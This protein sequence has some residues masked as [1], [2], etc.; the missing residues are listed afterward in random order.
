M[1]AFSSRTFGFGKDIFRRYPI[2]MIVITVTLLIAAVLEI[3]SL[4]AILPVMNNLLGSEGETSDS[5]SQI[6]NIVPFEIQTVAQGLAFIVIFMAFRGVFLFISQYLNGYVAT[7]LERNMRDEMMMAVLKADWKYHL[8]QN[9]G[10]LTS[11]IIKETEYCAFAVTKFGGF[12]VGLIISTIL[13]ITSIFVSWEAFLVFSISVLPYLLLGRWINR[14]IREYSAKRVDATAD[15]SSS[16]IDSLS[17]SK[18]IKAMALENQA[19]SRFEGSSKIVVKNDMKIALYKAL[20]TAY[21]EVFGIMTLSVLIYMMFTFD[22][23]N[24]Q[25]LV[26]F[27]LLMY[28]AYSQV[29]RM[30][31]SLSALSDYLPSYDV[32]KKMLLEAQG[33]EEKIKDQ[34]Y[35]PQKEGEIAIQN[36]SISYNDNDRIIENL[37]LSIA[38]NKVTAFVGRS[39][40]GKTTL[41]DALM[42]LIEPVQ[43]TIE[44]GQD[45]SSV[46]QVAFR[47]TI[48]YV[49]QDAY[50]IN[51][52]IRDNILIGAEDQSDENLLRVAKLAQIDAFAQDMPDGFDTLVGDRGGALSGGQKQRVALAR[53]LARKPDIL[54]LDE[55]T[56]ALDNETE[57]MVHEAINALRDNLTIILIAHRLSTVKDADQ[58]IMLEKGRIVD[59]G[60]FDALL[61]NNDGA[62]SK[63]YHHGT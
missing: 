38:K 39:G 7:Y 37:N 51:A 43:G 35:A 17:L 12:L 27:L 5:I 34:D 61:T 14:K 19:F 32:A 4:A 3:F 31:Y 42:G 21:P 59:Q 54:I 18:F 47:N 45:L 8:A 57:K 11:S 10:S 40:S 15:C 58:I 36:L 62:F 53:A 33:A 9:T 24:T 30:Q 28:R 26:F 16:V 1:I 13:L 55:A 6:L 23:L 48:G 44:A 2:P 52:S 56:S 20:V 60:T 63:L 49:P 50:L 29:A 22:L 46:N 41:V 25:E